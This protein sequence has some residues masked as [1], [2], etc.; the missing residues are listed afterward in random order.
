M[1]ESERE[2]ERER[3]CWSESVMCLRFL[4]TEKALFAISVHSPSSAISCFALLILIT[5]Y[6]LPFSPINQSEKTR[7][8]QSTCCRH[9][10]PLTVDPRTGNVSRLANAAAAEEEKEEQVGLRPRGPNES[11]LPT[12]LP[13]LFQGLSPSILPRLCST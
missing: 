11:P 10:A 8:R 4:V 7:R 1:A 9:L 12:W 5:Q 13:L 6:F 2:R 3:A